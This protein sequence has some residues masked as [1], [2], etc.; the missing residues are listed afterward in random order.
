MGLHESNHKHGSPISDHAMAA[1]RISSHSP[2][3]VGSFYTFAGLSTS[4]TTTA[5]RP[6]VLDRARSPECSLSCIFHTRGDETPGPS[7]RAFHPAWAPV[8]TL[9]DVAAIYIF[10]LV[11]LLLVTMTARL[12][13]RDSLQNF[14]NI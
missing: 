3:A 10:V 1:F 7:A 5:L 2:T 9:C 6:T 11:T 12:C 8:D 4:Y 13:A 14:G